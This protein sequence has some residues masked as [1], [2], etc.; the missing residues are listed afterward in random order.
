MAQQYPVKE[1]DIID[2]QTIQ[3]DKKLHKIIPKM[4]TVS[5]TVPY[6]E[7]RRTNKQQNSNC[8]DQPADEM[9]AAKALLFI[10]NRSQILFRR[11]PKKRLS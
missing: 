4:E 8:F 7:N 11:E 6:N 10:R 3:H 1:K 2:F 9:C 5:D